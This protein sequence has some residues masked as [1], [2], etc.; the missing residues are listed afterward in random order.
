[1]LVHQSPPGDTGRADSGTA[2]RASVG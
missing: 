2:S 1:M